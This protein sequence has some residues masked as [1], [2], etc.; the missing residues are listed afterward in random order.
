MK[1]T[2]GY[3]RRIMWA[4]IWLALVLKIPIVALFYL[5]WWAS[6][7]PETEE[8]P[9]EPRGGGSDRHWPPRPKHPNTPR[10]GPHAEPAPPAPARVRANGRALRERT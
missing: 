3:H 8:V 1:A 2:S 5:V 6:R 7:P 4:V 10:R 9:E